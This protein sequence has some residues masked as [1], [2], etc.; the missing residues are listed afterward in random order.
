[1]GWIGVTTIGYALGMTMSTLVVE[2]LGRPISP[3]LGGIAFVLMYG[4]VI[5]MVL[6]VAQFM[7]LPRGD[8][9]WERWIVATTV[10]AAVG[11]ALAALV[12]EALANVIDPKVNLVIG[13]GTIEDL[14][15]AMVGLAIGT[16]QWP[17]LR[18]VVP[19][20][21]WWIIASVVGVAL[22]YG[23]AE[24][25]LELFELT[26]LKSALVPSFGVIVGVFVGVAQA[27]VLR[28]RAWNVAKSAF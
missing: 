8:V 20:P 27:L 3:V 24:A 26:V 17:A 12:G 7:A 28:L 15:G 23:T 2:A 16:A 13:E 18:R 11:F 21:R 14:S 22:G 10:G 6:G 9:S 1:V 19:G 5:G 25:V 4:A